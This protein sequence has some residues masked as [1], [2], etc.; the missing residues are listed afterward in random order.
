MFFSAHIKPTS[1][2]QLRWTSAQKLCGFIQGVCF[3]RVKTTAGPRYIADKL[4][5]AQVEQV[6]NNV[7]VTLSVSAA[8]V[9][10]PP[11]KHPVLDVADLPLPPKRVKIK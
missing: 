8:R 11:E 6:R 4:S 3:V 10:P 7:A 2:V 5:E 9:P 1:T